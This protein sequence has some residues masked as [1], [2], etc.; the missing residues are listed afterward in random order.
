MCGYLETIEVDGC[1]VGKCVMV[2]QV[3]LERDWTDSTSPHTSDI[4]Y[5]ALLLSFAQTC[6]MR[7]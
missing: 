6:S 3:Q 2:A 4:A 5:R 7:H 1:K